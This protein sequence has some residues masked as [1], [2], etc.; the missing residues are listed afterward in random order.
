[1]MC[2]SSASCPESHFT[3]VLN[4]LDVWRVHFT[5]VC[6]IFD[7]RSISL[8]VIFYIFGVRSAILHYVLNISDAWRMHLVTCALLVQLMFFQSTHF[9]FVFLNKIFPFRRQTWEA[10]PFPRMWNIKPQHTRDMVWLELKPPTPR[11][12]SGG[13]PSPQNAPNGCFAT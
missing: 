7:V 11:L 10:C 1:M 3:W 8:P 4:T 9:E 6:N 2:F 5:C 12:S 13:T